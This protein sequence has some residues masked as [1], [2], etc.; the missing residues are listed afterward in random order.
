M[1]QIQWLESC[2]STQHELRER[3]L[4]NPELLNSVFATE[5]QTQGHGRKGRIWESPP[6]N[7]AFSI[8]FSVPDVAKAYLTNIL[9]AQVL[10][11][12]LEKFVP[13]VQFRLKWPNDI[14]CHNKKL[15]GLLS[16]LLPNSNTVLLGIGLNLNS[17][18]TAFSK[19]LQNQIITI[20]DLL[21]QA[22]PVESFLKEFIL[23]F[24]ASLPILHQFGLT[25]LLPKIHK[26]L[27]FLGEEV[28]L[29]ENDRVVAQ[30]TLQGIDE[31]G[32]LLLHCDDQS[33]VKQLTGDLTL[34]A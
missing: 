16:E 29:W 4:R 21:G 27:Q 5:N 17:T 24:V 14:W 28:T 7:L 20:K 2:E 22:V 11:E 10:I 26:H 23:R 12:T 15:A 6:G 19:G 9:A 18:K 25:T 8:I 30:G 32:H 33:V 34:R 31:A 1:W 13:H 3:F